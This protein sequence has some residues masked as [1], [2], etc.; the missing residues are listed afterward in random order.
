MVG[1]LKMSVERCRSDADRENPKYRKKNLFQCYFVHHKSHTDW[2]GI[3][4][5]C[6]Q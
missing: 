3:E 5:E 1:E 6:P 4:K 2:P